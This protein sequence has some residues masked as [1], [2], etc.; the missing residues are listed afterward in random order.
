M[1]NYLDNLGV[2]PDT[3]DDILNYIRFPLST[4]EKM[5]ALVLSLQIYEQKT[6]ARLWGQNETQ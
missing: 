5:F 6:A 2:R 4:R 1:K 3:T